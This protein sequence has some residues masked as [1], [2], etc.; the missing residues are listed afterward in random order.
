MN[1]TKNYHEQGGEKTVIGGILEIATG[2]KLTFNNV[3]FSPDIIKGD[4]GAPGAKGDKGDPGD[5]G[6][7]TPTAYQTDS[8]ATTIAD[9]KADFNA[10]LSK[11]KTAG[12]M[13]VE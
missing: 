4:T 13:A 10:L 1:N 12:I 8:T 9:L 2:G 6:T 11:L 5:P 7:V 3:E